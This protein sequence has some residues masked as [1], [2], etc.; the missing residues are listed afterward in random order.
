MLVV[1][2]SSVDLLVVVTGLV[3][4]DDV[5]GASVVKVTVVVSGSTVVKQLHGSQHKPQHTSWRY[6]TCDSIVTTI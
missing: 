3:V 6:S 5:N 1:D 2:G 4:R